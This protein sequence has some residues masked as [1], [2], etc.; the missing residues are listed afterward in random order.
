[1]ATLSKAEAYQLALDNDD[2]DLFA[3][4]YRMMTDDELARVY[5][6]YNGRWT[7]ANQE[8]TCMREIHKR[9][10][11]KAKEREQQRIIDERQAAIN[12]TER[13]ASIYGRPCHRNM[14]ADISW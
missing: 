7:S 9:N 10:E 1:M 2:Y 3:T 4:V 13:R 8:K 11:A 6:G 5:S 14:R 12:Q